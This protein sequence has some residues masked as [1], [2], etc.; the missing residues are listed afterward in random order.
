M[1]DPA[2]GPALLRRIL[3]DPADDQPRRCY[4]DWLLDRSGEGDAE[5]AEFIR[6]QIDGH[7]FTNEEWADY[8]A[9]AIRNPAAWGFS[10]H[11]LYSHVVW[12]RGF[13][14]SLSLPCAAFMT[15]AAA[16]FAA[17]PIEKVTLTDKQPGREGNGHGW[18]FEMNGTPPRSHD[19]PVELWRLLEPY[20]P[21]E[22]IDAHGW[23]DCRNE[24]L[25]ALHNV[26]I[27]YGR[28]AAGIDQPPAKDDWESYHEWLRDDTPAASR[29]Q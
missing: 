20:R 7:N 1:F 26:L 12:E 4:A 25:A 11:S 3:E 18:D 27:R 28:L 8:A 29:R 5:R 14:G 21:D 13:V 22:Q 17:H 10:N 15:H 23:Y 2:D 24:A 9:E 16:L 19:L 6:K